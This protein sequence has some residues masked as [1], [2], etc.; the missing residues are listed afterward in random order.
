MNSPVTVCGQGSSGAGHGGSNGER[1]QHWGKAAV[2]VGVAAESMGTA[3]VLV[4]MATE[5]MG[6]AA[7]LVGRVHRLATC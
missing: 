4:G 2:L 6:T 5:S 3:A 1:W 7:A